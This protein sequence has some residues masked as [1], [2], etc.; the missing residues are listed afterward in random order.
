MKSNWLDTLRM[1]ENLTVLV[2]CIVPFYEPRRQWDKG[3]FVHALKL[4]TK[5]RTPKAHTV[6]IENFSFLCS[7][8]VADKV[9]KNVPIV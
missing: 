1:D 9:N 4:T 6:V 3:Q 7:F 2:I 8:H 5:Q